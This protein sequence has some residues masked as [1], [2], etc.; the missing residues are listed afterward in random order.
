M[1]TMSTIST[2]GN[3]FIS[4]PRRLL[5]G[6][7]GF[8]MLFT[9]LFSAFYIISEATHE[10]P[11]LSHAGSAASHDAS[12]AS[13][14]HSEENCPICACIRQCEITLRGLGNSLTRQL[15]VIVPILFV[16]LITFSFVT[17]FLQETLVSKKIRL[18]D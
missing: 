1:S 4:R 2:L 15:A 18:N 8:L 12:A 6:I 9:V 16:L 10:C 14:D 7:I 11:A 17:V 13:H 3:I 5:S